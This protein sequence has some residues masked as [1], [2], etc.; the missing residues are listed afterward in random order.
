MEFPVRGINDLYGLHGH[1]VTS[2]SVPLADG[3]RLYIILALQVAPI[4]DTAGAIRVLPP[5]CMPL[6]QAETIARDLIGCAKAL[7]GTRRP[8][9]K[10]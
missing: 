7:R 8:A 2:V 4:A 5:V 3:E 9:K 10:H 1:N 6:E